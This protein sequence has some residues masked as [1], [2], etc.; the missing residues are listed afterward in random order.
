[1]VKI[2]VLS[3]QS[4]FWTGNDMNNCRKWPINETRG[5]KTGRGGVF[6]R[7]FCPNVKM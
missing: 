4:D 2:G 5:L 7:L 1:M 3:I 6:E